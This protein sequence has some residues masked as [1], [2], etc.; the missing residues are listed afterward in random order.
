MCRAAT[1]KVAHLTGDRSA[2]PVLSEALLPESRRFGRQSGLS[3]LEIIVA[4]ALLA[5]VMTVSVQSGAEML[6]RWQYRAMVKDVRNRIAG[7]P[8]RAAFERQPVELAN[9]PA[10]EIG[11][12]E[13]WLIEEQAPLVFSSSGLCSAAEFSLID[14]AGRRHTFTVSPPDCLPV[15]PS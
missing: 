6:E 9:I 15:S 7:L 5:I 8:L 12:P 2:C 13:G 1:E 4:M 11:L 10:D 3:L 14:P